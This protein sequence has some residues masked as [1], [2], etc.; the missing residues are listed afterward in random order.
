M[1]FSTAEIL[2]EG[3]PLRAALVELGNAVIALFWLGEEPK[4]GT[5]TISLP[6]GVSSTLLGDRDRMLG[7][8]I[9]ERLALL[10]GKTVLVSINLPPALGASAGRTLLELAG[11]LVRGVERSEDLPRGAGL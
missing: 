4:L 8:M 10:Y 9:G 7:Q 1:E 11:E 5:L 6:G 3:R 2:F